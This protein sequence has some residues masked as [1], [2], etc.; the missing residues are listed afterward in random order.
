[1]IRMTKQFRGTAAVLLLFLGSALGLYAQ[2]GNDTA[3]LP[4][5][6][7]VT[8]SLAAVENLSIDYADDEVILR[9]SR[10][11]ELI[12]RE[13][14]SK[15]R[16][17]YYANV[18]RSGDSLSI[19]RGRRPWFTWTWKARVEI[20]LP[21][22]FRGNL[23]LAI[24]SG[25]FRSEIDLPD[26]KTIDVSV[27][28]GSVFCKQLSAETVSVRLSSGN[29]DIAGIGG[30]SFIS[31][32]SGGMRIGTLSG[33]EHRIRTS[34]GRMEI[35]SIRGGSAIEISSG[36]IIIDGIAGDAAI[37]VQSGNVRIGELTGT[38]HRVRSSSGRT[39]IENVRGRMD[40]N[41][42]SGSVN[43]ENFSGEG[44]FE[45]SSG[46]L[47]LDMRELTGDLQITVSSGDIFLN[48]PRG[49]AFN[50]DAV[51][52][53]GKI[54][55]NEGGNELTQVSGFSTVFRPIGTSP[56]R[57]IRA[58]TSSGSLRIDLRN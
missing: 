24:S 2:R 46:D 15:D 29:L 21:P 39:R 50:L 5:V 40:V 4:L 13:Y 41:V 8:L 43:I 52:N 10:T 25:T 58:R 54:L 18:S 16:S 33:R 1:M 11:G 48:L 6:N 12:V 32:S 49:S 56:E 34:S 3:D 38:S 23:R 7:T 28:S 22:S 19:R 9:E 53:S 47:T 35:G 17:Q 45:T 30:A 57:T 44:R 55:I 37:E 51:T 14:M 42:S 20:D 27:S 31:I 36:S 26:F